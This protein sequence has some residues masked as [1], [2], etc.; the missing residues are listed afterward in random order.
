MSNMGIREVHGDIWRGLDA[1][2]N[3][4]L[5]SNEIS[6]LPIVAFNSLTSLKCLNLDLNSISRVETGAFTGLLNMESL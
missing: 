5:Q 2:E 6:T 4:N 3:S 1:L